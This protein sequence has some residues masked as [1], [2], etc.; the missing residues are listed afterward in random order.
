M[1]RR[2]K[3]WPKGKK[4][5]LHQDGVLNDSQK[6]STDD[7]IPKVELVGRGFTTRLV[8]EN[9]PYILRGRLK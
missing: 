9:D 6:L 7:V 5:K 8:D 1:K 3:K 2:K 4:S